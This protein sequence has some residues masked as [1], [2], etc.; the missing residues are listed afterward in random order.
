MLMNSSC[1]V[2]VIENLMCFLNA[3]SFVEQR[4]L[5]FKWRKGRGETH[6]ARGL[7]LGRLGT[8]EGPI[9]RSIGRET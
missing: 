2:F 9:V 7:W 3:C 6:V 1:N 8:K 4:S 5:N